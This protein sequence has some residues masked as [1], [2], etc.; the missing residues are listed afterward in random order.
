MKH[1]FPALLVLP[2]LLAG[3]DARAEARSKKSDQRI[4]LFQKDNIKHSGLKHNHTIAL[5][6]DDGPNSATAE[7]LEELREHDIKATFFVVGRMARTH[8][9]I[10]A[11]VAAEGHLLANHSDSHPKLGRR[12]VNSPPR[13]VAQIRNT[14]DEIA[15]L[16][17]QT[18]KLFFR[19][20]YG[21]WRP[22]HARVLNRDPV[23]RKYIG[24]IYWDVGGAT[25]MTRDGYIL[26]SADWSCWRRGWT[27]KTCA[28]GYLREIRRKDGGVVLMHSINAKSRALVSAVVKPQRWQ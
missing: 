10:L 24:P 18:D 23:L 4:A 6:F 14:H 27:A 13:L 25:S 8:P 21:Y 12:Y 17:R 7:V 20:P 15:P 19:A 11:Q 22:A 28:K 26:S 9:K 1:I 3:C 5:T 2:L 16:V